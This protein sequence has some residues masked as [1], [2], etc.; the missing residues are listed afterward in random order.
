MNEGTEGRWTR[1]L[2]L[3]KKI[4]TRCMILT[5]FAS[6]FIS[7]ACSETRSSIDL[8]RA[9]SPGYPCRN[10]LRPIQFFTENEL[11]VYSS[12]TE[13]DCYRSVNQLTLNLISIEG[14]GLARRTWPSSDPGIVIN[15][16]RLVLATPNGLEVDDQ[17]L[18][19]VQALELP[20]HRFTGTFFIH[21]QGTVTV[22]LD[23]RELLLYGDTPL[24]LLG[25]DD[26][27]PA[28]RRWP[29]FEFAD[30]QRII[31]DGESLN[32]QTQGRADRTIA[33]LDWVLPP[34]K[35]KGYVNCQAYDA[36]T[37]IHV[38]TGR[39]RRVLVFSNGSRFPVTDAA[40]L[41]PYFRLQVFDV[42]SGK[43]V[44]REEYVTRTGVRYACIS[45]DGDRLATTDGQTIIIRSLL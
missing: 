8:K 22:I 14:R 41:F 42:D 39:K 32:M 38:S 1:G 37:T 5:A 7:I 12:G 4:G 23:G 9:L 34:C 27:S 31:R 18:T 24:R 16:G 13:G 35:A 30:G 45:P 28:K 3:M 19:P 15:P 25:Q 44:Y 20:Q 21:K 11:L 10:F 17:T 36:G 2:R 6:I 29:D 33:N 43:Q 40:G 26:L